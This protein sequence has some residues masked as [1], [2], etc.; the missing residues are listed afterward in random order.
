MKQTR[1]N[2]EIGAKIPADLQADP[3]ESTSGC[4]RLGK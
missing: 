2:Y 3:E 1:I 4:Y